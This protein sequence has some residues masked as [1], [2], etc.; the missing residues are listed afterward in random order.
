MDARVTAVLDAYHERMRAEDMDRQSRATDRPDDWRDRQ[1][2]A[3]GP[4]TGRLINIFAR[5]LPAP[6]I[7][8]R[9]TSHGYSGIWLAEAARAA[10]GRLTTMELQDHK[11]AYARDMATKAGPGRPRRLQGRRRRRDDR[12]PAVPSGLRARRPLEGPLR[13]VPR[14]A[15]YPQTQSRGILVADNISRPGGELVRRYAEAVRAK[16]G[17]SSVLLPVGSGI[18]VSRFEPS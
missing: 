9:G 8:E 16:P 4:G 13:P 10:G 14:E 5:S 1:L 7:L 2:L 11:S 6:N 12:R 15:F 17:M 18:D 3:V